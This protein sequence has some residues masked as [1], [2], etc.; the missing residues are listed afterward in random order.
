MMSGTE[1]AGVVI[2]VGPGLTGRKVGDV[3]A[4]VLMGAYA[5]EK[6]LPAEKVV[7]LPHSIDPVIA[8]AIMLKGMTAQILL[9]QCIKVG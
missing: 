3:V 6:I 7:P 1:A 4:Y 8:A 5:E 9:R 2:A